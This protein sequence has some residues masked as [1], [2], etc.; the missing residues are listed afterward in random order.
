MGADP[1]SPHVGRGPAVGMDRAGGSAG[2]SRFA[3]RTTGQLPVD[4]SGFR[5]LRAGETAEGGALMT[6]QGRRTLNAQGRRT[7]NA[8]PWRIWD[9]WI[10]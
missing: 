8:V 4:R 9:D 2:R 7:L 3:R 5:N 6:S 1:A 10:A